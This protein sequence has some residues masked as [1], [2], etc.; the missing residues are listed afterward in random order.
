MYIYACRRLQYFGGTSIL[1]DRRFRFICLHDLI[2]CNVQCSAEPFIPFDIDFDIY[3]MVDSVSWVSY[4]LTSVIHEG[5]KLSRSGF[6]YLMASPSSVY[7]GK[8]VCKSRVCTGLYLY[9][10]TVLWHHHHSSNKI[11]GA[12][13]QLQS[14]DHW[15]DDYY[16][17]SY[18][19]NSRH[20]WIIPSKCYRRRTS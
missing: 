2:G 17:W 10:L 15:Y 7:G 13:A 1:Y 6:H 20:W 16:S 5:I 18:F 14:Y 11:G 9:S 4:H 12:F 8:P 19:D 3:R